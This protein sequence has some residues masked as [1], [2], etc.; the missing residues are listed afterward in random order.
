MILEAFF[1]FFIFVLPSLIVFVYKSI[2]WNKNSEKK[3][4]IKYI[5]TDYKSVI[6]VAVIIS[7]TLYIS[8][9]V[10]DK[11][12]FKNNN[13]L[14]EYYERVNN[15]DGLEGIYTDLIISDSLN[16]TYN[17]YKIYYH[18]K[19]VEY[20]D[21]GYRFKR[22]DYEIKEFYK[23]YRSDTNLD[24]NT[25]WNFYL[26]F[27]NIYNNDKNKAY[28]IYD[29]TG[30][31]TVKYVN[32][33]M[34]FS[35]KK[36]EE[37]KQF[38]LKEIK[39]NGFVESSY[40]QLVRL[41]I[42]YGK[43]NDAY[44]LM[45]TKNLAEIIPLSLKSD[46]EFINGKYLEF[47]K[48]EYYKSYK[49][50]TVIGF[51]A[52]F[53]ILLIWIIFLYKLDIYKKD[54]I[55]KLI[56]T[57]F[58]GAIF[59][60]LS[61][62][63]YNYSGFYWGFTITGE[64][65]NDLL[66]SIFGIGLFEEII[67]L[68]PFLF[69]YIIWRKEF[70]EPYDYILYIVMSALGFAFVENLMYFSE[71]VVHTI[72]VRSVISSIGHMFFSATIAYGIILSVYRY[73]GYGILIIPL[74]FLFAILGHGLFDYLL[75]FNHEIIFAFYF[76]IITKIFLT[77][78]NNAINNSAY[79]D[80]KIKIETKKLRQFLAISLTIVFAI[81]YLYTSW[82]YYTEYAVYT[83]NAYKLTSFFVLIFIADNFTHF[84][85][86]KG[87]WRVFDFSLNPF[88]IHATEENFIDYKIT[89]KADTSGENLNRYFGINKPAQ[90]IDRISITY[91]SLWMKKKK[92]IENNW[93]VVLL[94][95]PIYFENKPKTKVFINFVSKAVTLFKKE[96]LAYIMVIDDEQ[97]LKDE[98]NREH[99]KLL[100][101]VSVKRIE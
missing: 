24:R 84:D 43:Y 30:L 92:L 91:S 1:Y 25:I 88:K 99:F 85:I 29:T 81:E 44:E 39:N 32:Y 26:F 10:F 94:D 93:F 83:L 23:N 54:N 18:Y 58:L 62:F 9:K 79:F 20:N 97:L 47:L 63:L 80:Y 11:P 75:F 100:G 90:I 86:I 31:S 73:K 33:Y 45:H 53:L 41:Y 59:T 95:E 28:K 67:K 60:N 87:N 76:L 38:L 61:L 69:V 52:A 34:S 66:Y 50:T 8:S 56:F 17:Y 96:E 36:L 14:I 16:L 6:A 57:V 55:A 98:N 42:E 78:I 19:I 101:R 68:I 12:Q 13:E 2:I 35:S 51:I 22:Q 65:T 27:A 89:I 77:Y 49:E 48:T 71:G 4:Y 64:K 5:I 72:S 21:R 40:I 46:V 37:R 74:F 3:S 15:Y 82:Y 7:S 70:K